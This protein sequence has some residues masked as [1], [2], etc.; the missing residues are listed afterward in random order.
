MSPMRIFVLGIWGSRT[1]GANGECL[2]AV[3]LWRRHG[4]DVTLIPTWT[5]ASD[6][7]RRTATGMGCE[8]V[9]SHPR[10]LR[11]I[12]GLAG[13]TVVN[14]CN[15][16]AY[17]PKTVLKEMGCRFIAAP[18]MCNPGM[19]FRTAIKSGHVDAVVYQS[20]YQKTKMEQRLRSWGYDPKIGRLIRGYL[21]WEAIEFKPLPHVDGEPF[22]LGRVARDARDKWHPHWWKMYERVPNR[23][24]VVLGYGRPI[25]GQC[26]KPPSWARAYFPNE[27]TADSVYR[28][29]HA[30]VTRND[31]IDEN[32]PRTG[33]EAMAYGVPIVAENDFGWREMLENGVSG[34]LADSWEETGDLAA[35]LAG[36]E[37]LRLEIATA[38]RERLA[39]ICDGEE[40]WSKWKEL[41]L[42][43]RECN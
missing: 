35:K 40:I 2:G 16:N 28:Q 18:C 13:S 19:G 4:L 22:V 11:E 38:A 10:R 5:P 27:V 12:P 42:T 25:Y 43:T 20:Q 33:L 9:D 39:V 1:G 26:G 14:F 23:Q 34:L 6:E 17:A 24:A 31:T 8:I 3:Q 32:W 21:D 29:L 41:F 37:S 30:Y 15:E 36:D 7:A